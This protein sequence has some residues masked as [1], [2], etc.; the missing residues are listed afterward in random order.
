MKPYCFSSD[1]IILLDFLIIKSKITIIPI[2]VQSL[3]LRLPVYNVQR[4]SV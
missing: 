4:I 2:R 1:E 3:D